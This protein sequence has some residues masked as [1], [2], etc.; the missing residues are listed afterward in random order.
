MRGICL[1]LW[2]RS[3]LFGFCPML[4]RSTSV[5]TVESLEVSE[6]PNLESIRISCLF[7]CFHLATFF[8]RCN[9][10]CC[11]DVCSRVHQEVIDIHSCV[12]CSQKDPHLNVQDW[13]ARVRNRFRLERVFALARRR[14]TCAFFEKRPISPAN[15]TRFAL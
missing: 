9:C 7:S 8:F 1:S 14:T 4:L 13:R 2:N 15:T 6:M 3:R 10:A 5:L 12:V 11:V